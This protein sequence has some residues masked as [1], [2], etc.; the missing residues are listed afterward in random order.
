MGE[1]EI[2][3]LKH[4]KSRELETLSLEEIS[5]YLWLLNKE[6]K[7]NDLLVLWQQYNGPQRRFGE[8]LASVLGLQLHRYNG[9]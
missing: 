6:K 8:R 3:L 1:L 4:Y 7:E 9:S 5:E 2:A